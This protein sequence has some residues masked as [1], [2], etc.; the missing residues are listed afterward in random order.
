MIQPAGTSPALP[1]SNLK[2]GFFSWAGQAE[3]AHSTATRLT[4]DRRAVIAESCSRVRR[5]AAACRWLLSNSTRNNGRVHT[6]RCV[7]FWRTL[8]VTPPVRRLLARQTV[9]HGLLTTRFPAAILLHRIRSCHGLPCTAG[10][11]K[12]RSSQHLNPDR[13]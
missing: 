8:F 6:R 10:Q 1:A 12:G 3:L 2:S 4:M 5:P 7:L 11:P 13:G 9:H